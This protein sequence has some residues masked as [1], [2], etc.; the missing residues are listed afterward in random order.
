M[1]T[2]F[3]GQLRAEFHAGLLE[4]ALTK[5]EAGV[6]SNADSNNRLSRNIASGIVAQIK[7][8]VA[9]SDKRAGQT[10]GNNFELAVNKFLQC[11]FA[12]LGHIRPGNWLFLPDINKLD[13]IKGTGDSIALSIVGFEQFAHL[14]TLDAIART[15]PE[16]AL[17]LGNSYIIRP[18]IIVARWPE[19][20]TTINQG[21]EFVDSAIA[22]KTALRK[23]NNQRPIL[24]ASI[25]CK[26]TLRSDRA[27][28][29]RT[30][31]LNLI[32]NRKGRVPHI[33][34]VTA[35]PLPSRLASLALGT[36]D[37][38]CVYHFALKELQSTVSDL[39]K[40]SEGKQMLL[41]LVNGL[42]LKD[43]AD[44]PLDLAI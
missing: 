42:R 16:V 29:A 9:T 23:V 18:D 30:E 19:E 35:E 4:N 13:A 7:Q 43:I 28:N 10:L 14:N 27:Q 34:V 32:R 37:V 33:V 22:N 2:S 36:G 5:S 12:K 40:E 31:A 38:D 6:W 3:L 17:A 24:H 41:N 1:T 25:S 26:W 11:S 44:L 21:V 15:N 8:E 39:P 20:E